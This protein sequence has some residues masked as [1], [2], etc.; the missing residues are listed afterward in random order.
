MLNLSEPIKIGLSSI[1]FGS[2]N[3]ILIPSS[4]TK[5]HASSPVSVFGGLRQWMKCFKSF[6]QND[7]IKT[8]VNETSSSY[9]LILDLT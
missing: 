1:I 9:S 4:E 2:S 3:I 7:V 8:P 6:L 5:T